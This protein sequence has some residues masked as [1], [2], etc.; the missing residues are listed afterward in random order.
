MASATAAAINTGEYVGDLD[1]TALGPAETRFGLE[2]F[3]LWRIVLWCGT[4]A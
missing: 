2:R 1:G 3:R 4:G